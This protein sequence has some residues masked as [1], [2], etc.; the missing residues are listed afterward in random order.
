MSSGF[1][2]DSPGEREADAEDLREP[3]RRGQGRRV[4]AGAS[5]RDAVGGDSPGGGDGA[6]GGLDLVLERGDRPLQE[7]DVIEMGPDQHGVVGA[8]HHAVQGPLDGG[9]VALDLRG[10]GGE[11]PGGALAV[12]EGLQDGAGGLRPGQRRD[13]ARQLD[14]G[15]FEE[16]VQPL[17]FSGAVA[18]Q[19]QPGADQ[20]PQRPDLRR[21]HERRLLITGAATPRNTPWPA[22]SVTDVIR[23][24]GLSVKAAVYE[25]LGLKVTYLSG[26]DKLRAHVAIS[27]ETFV[28]KSE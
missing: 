28:P 20:V 10:Q 13:R 8:G 27:P 9:S 5:G 14:Q 18:D 3:L 7:R 4:R 2:D 25:Q 19:L 26:Q 17:P 22:T 12:G 23:D 21:R 1:G 6:E 15:S 16:L 11:G 24:A